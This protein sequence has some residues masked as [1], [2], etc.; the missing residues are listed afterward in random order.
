[1]K[2]HTVVPGESIRSVAKLYG[3]PETRILFDN[4]LDPKNK[5]YPG[6]TLVVGEPTQTDSVRGGDTLDRI[7]ARNDTD[8]CAL[9]QS[10]PRLAEGGLV[11][12]QPLNIEYAR[13]TARRLLVHAYTGT[14]G[15]TVLRKRLPLVS[16][17]SVQ[18]AALLQNG[19]VRLPETAAR[20]AAIAREYRALPILCIEANDPWGRHDT[21]AVTQ[22]IASPLLTERLIQ[23]ALNAVE[24][25]GFAGIELDFSPLP[26][27][28]APRLTELLSALAAR[29]EECGLY[30]LSPWQ[31]NL[32]EADVLTL[33]RPDIADLVPIHSYLY[34]DEKTA[35]PAAPL[36]RA[37]AAL[38][39]AFVPHSAGKLLLGIP[40][41][42]IDYTKTANGYRKRAADAARLCGLQPPAAVTFD[43]ISRTP[44][45]AYT[46]E[47]HNFP[48]EHRLCY[49]D[50][51]SFVSKLG[52]ADKLSLGG[53]SICSLAYDA[54]LLWQ[55]L[56]QTY[57]VV[58]Y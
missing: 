13:E 5:L 2:I 37:E 24:A 45:A 54:P 55:L 12:S 6:Q 3:V 10:N 34:D 47:S 33:N 40:T 15:E 8:V 27:D 11:P 42:G 30:L 26:P 22:I 38:A 50:A 7:A 23:S 31:P 44:C 4:E 21:S 18:N 41:F 16:V 56:N 29:C 48:L 28:D 19:R 46:E 1:M 49:E 9:L 20:T 52:L 57:S 43:S 36:D 14:A 35:S 32:P 53:V 25:G 58:K 39:A 51:N 17:L